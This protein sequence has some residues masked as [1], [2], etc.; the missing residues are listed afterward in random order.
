MV[1]IAVCAE[2]ERDRKTIESCMKEAIRFYSLNSHV[3]YLE[4]GEALL[5]TISEGRT[6]NLVILDILMEH[7]NG[8]ETVQEV[9]KRHPDTMIAFI[10]ESAESEAEVFSME[11]IHYILKP[12][13]A[14]TIRE[15]VAR[16]LKKQNR[17]VKLLTLQ[18]KKGLVEIPE[19]KVIRF[20]SYK[21]GVSVIF[22]SEESM[23]LKKT[24]MEL[25][26]ELD[27]GTFCK[28]S[29]GLIVRMGYI[30]MIRDGTCYFTDGTSSLISRKLRVSVRKRY[31]DYLSEKV[32]LAGQISDDSF[33]SK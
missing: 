23:W 33:V 27:T 2:N 14:F 13:T 16:Y 30:Q 19:Y 10:T 25:E 11:H 8:M 28:I 3:D 32:Q 7:M 21:K 24:F 12:V 4:S 6:Y 9:V 18:T 5:K 20:E 26:N 17:P 15:L 31:I 1:R 29:R 22:R